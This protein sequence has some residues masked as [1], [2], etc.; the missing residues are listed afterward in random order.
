MHRPQLGPDRLDIVV[1]EERGKGVAEAGKG[2][3][4]GQRIALGSDGREVALDL[5]PGKEV[6]AIV[7]ANSLRT[8]ILGAK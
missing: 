8:V 3:Q 1:A 4:A 6:H 2:F 7:K 5:A